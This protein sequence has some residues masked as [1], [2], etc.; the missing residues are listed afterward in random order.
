MI[1][2]LR[3][4]SMCIAIVLLL[5]CQ[6]Q[7]KEILKEV[8]ATGSMTDSQA[9]ILSNEKYLNLRTLKVLSD[10]QAE[11][12][13][14]VPNL[15]LPGITTLTDQQAESL[16]K[17]Q[18][19]SL[20]GL[21][22]LTDQQAES[23]S[24]VQS[25]SLNGLSS[26]TDQQAKSLSK[27]KALVIMNDWNGI[28]DQQTLILSDVPS[29][30]L[31]LPALSDRQAE[32]LG[33][34][35]ER[36]NLPRL[37][38]LSDRQAESLSNVPDLSLPKITTLTDYQAECLGN[39]PGLYLSGLTT[40]TDQQ[41]KSLGRAESVFLQGLTS[42]TDQQAESLNELRF[43][44]LGGLT[45]ITDQQAESLSNVRSL[46]LGGLTSISE[47]QAK[48]LKNIDI[49]SISAACRPL[50]DKYRKT[51][52]TKVTEEL[53][54][55]M[56][57]DELLLVEIEPPTPNIAELTK[58]AT[59]GDADA[60]F[61]LGGVYYEGKHVEQDY[62]KAM[63]WFRMAAEQGD[64]TAQYNLGV[65]YRDGDGVKVDETESMKWFRLAA[66]RF[67]LPDSVTS[68]GMEFKLIPAGTF[69]MGEGDQ[70]HEVTLT[71]AFRI[72]VHEVTQAQYEQVMR[73][74]PSKFK[75]ANNPVGRVRW[76]DAVKFCRKLS[77]LPAEKEAGNVYR[78]PTEAEWEYA[79]RAGTTT[80]FSFGDDESELGDYGWYD[81]SAIKGEGGLPSPDTYPVGEKQPNAWGLYDMH[82]NVDEWCQDWFGDYPSGSVTDPSGSPSGSYRVNRGGSVRVP[83]KNCRSAYRGRATLQ[84]RYCCIGFRV[85]LSPS[86]K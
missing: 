52:N 73:D 9:E 6:Q 19:L 49:W 63:D 51:E 36:L 76:A 41:A 70:A 29:L 54:L 83:A 35:D 24:K 84:A 74:N 60:Q 25:L 22:S 1:R 14:K 66:A 48:S 68:I 10:R 17:V 86:G 37:T 72:G 42:I 50:I 58:K 20:D 62:A 78:L 23:L 59:E 32:I 33:A 55:P 46:F 71:K 7:P 11:H 67:K 12:L 21:S 2:Q 31:G 82:G 8:N 64:K 69:I 15:S 81:D 85:C 18:S 44:H 57:G 53:P 56:V 16:S 13:S 30:G 3:S 45:S 39:V 61:T 34:V 47:A 79:C 75:S 4:L 28:T 43:L 26:L 77:E 65:M 5:G 38:T 80:K 27:L 40:L